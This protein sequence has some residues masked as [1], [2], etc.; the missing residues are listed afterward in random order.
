MTM[1]TID[2]IGLYI[3]ERKNQRPELLW[4]YPMAANKPLMGFTLPHTKKFSLVGEKKKGNKE[5]K[6]GFLDL[7]GRIVFINVYKIYFLYFVH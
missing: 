6:R 2:H 3:G 7:L 1:G 5:N 4:R